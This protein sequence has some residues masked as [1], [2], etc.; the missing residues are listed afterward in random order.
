MTQIFSDCF[1]VPQ[2]S[3]IYTDLDLFGL[4]DDADFSSSDYAELSDEKSAKSAKS[5]GTTVNDHITSLLYKEICNLLKQSD[6]TMG[7]IAD[8]LH[9]S[10]QSAMTNFFKMRA[11]MTPLAYRNQG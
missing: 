8:H 11:G 5:A 4:W 9:F 3:Q 1:F 7:E 2:I 6:M 10:D